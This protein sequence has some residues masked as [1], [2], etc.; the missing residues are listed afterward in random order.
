MSFSKELTMNLEQS[1]ILKGFCNDLENQ[2]RI[3]PKCAEE[4]RIIITLRLGIEFN[5]DF[6]EL[7]IICLTNF[8]L[9]LGS[10][11]F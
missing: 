1:E 5:Q 4:L 7:H 11:R 6:T 8:L 2:E 3:C 9:A 10:N